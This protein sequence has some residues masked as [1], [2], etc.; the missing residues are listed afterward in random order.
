[1][2]G[3][4]KREN[5]YANFRRRLPCVR[6]SPFSAFKSPLWGREMAHRTQRGRHQAAL[7]RYVVFVGQTPASRQQRLVAEVA[8]RHGEGVLDCAYISA[9]ASGGC[10]LAAW[11][12][13]VHCGHVGEHRLARGPRHGDG[14][15]LRPG[16]DHA[17]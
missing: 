14:H 11:R 17:G 7:K 2:M 5:R 16:G 8:K 3:C 15:H 6:L 13:A 4:A 12:L 9:T 10:L 1:M